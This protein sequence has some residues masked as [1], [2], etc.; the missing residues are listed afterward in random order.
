MSQKDLCLGCIESNYQEIV[1]VSHLLDNGMSIPPNAYVVLDHVAATRGVQPPPSIITSVGTMKVVVAAHRD[2]I[3][4]LLLLR[5]SDDG[6]AIPVE[7]L[8]SS[9]KTL[10]GSFVDDAVMVHVSLLIFSTSTC[11]IRNE[12]QITDFCASQPSLNTTSDSVGCAL[13]PSAAHTFLIE[14]LNAW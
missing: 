14:R 7:V 8:P 12:S 2:N 9:L 4:H 13:C 10:A 6:A 11:K 5:S 3:Q 1:T